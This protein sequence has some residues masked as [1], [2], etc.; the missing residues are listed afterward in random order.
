MAKKFTDPYAGDPP[1]RPVMDRLREL[2]FF[3]PHCSGCEDTL[4]EVTS[5]SDGSNMLV[6]KVLQVPVGLYDALEDKVYGVWIEANG[7]S[8]CPLQG[9]HPREIITL[10]EMRERVWK[11]EFRDEFR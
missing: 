1:F 2:G 9:Y 4:F 6:Q 3:E 10:E 5:F 7:V 11:K 8:C